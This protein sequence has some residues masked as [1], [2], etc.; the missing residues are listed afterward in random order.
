MTTQEI[1]SNGET[2]IQGVIV[3]RTVGFLQLNATYTQKL[4]AYLR[5]K[6]QHIFV[7]TY[8]C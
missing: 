4:L 8:S 5:T 3:F 7:M 1:S 6:M 2:M